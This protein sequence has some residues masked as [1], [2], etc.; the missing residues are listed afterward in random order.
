[1]VR[2]DV[3]LPLLEYRRNPREYF[4]NDRLWHL[5]QLLSPAGSEIQRARLIAA[6]HPSCLCASSGQRNRES[7]EAGKAAAGRNRYDDGNLRHTVERFRRDDQDGTAS[8]LLMSLC[9]IQANQPNL[10]ALHGIRVGLNELG[11]GRFPTDPIALGLA[12][13]S[14][15]FLWRGTAHRQKVGQTV[16]GT[17]LWLDNEASVYHGYTDFRSRLEVE[18]IQ[19]RGRYSQHDRTT[20]FPQ[21]GFV[22]I[23]S[24]LIILQSYY[25]LV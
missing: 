25:T 9:R 6:D 23:K 10:S 16:P 8:L 17:G 4:V 18:D 21:V 11:T 22:H 1:M 3:G 15:R 13:A 14:L 5:F 2:R 12:A 20:D 24:S 7:S 19:Q